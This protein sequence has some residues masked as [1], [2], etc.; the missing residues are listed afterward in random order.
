MYEFY[1]NFRQKLSVHKIKSICG[2]DRIISS[3][4]IFLSVLC[5]SVQNIFS[6]YKKIC[7]NNCNFHYLTFLHNIYLIV[8]LGKIFLFSSVCSYKY[9]FKNL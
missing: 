9:I 3:E 2:Y 4:D 6:V 7:V 8:G 1:F 5:I